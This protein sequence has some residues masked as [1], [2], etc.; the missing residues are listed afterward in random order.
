MSTQTREPFSF[1]TRP[2]TFREQ[3]ILH[4]MQKCGAGTRE[5][6]D[7]W[8]LFVN[9]MECRLDE[10][11]RIPELFGLDMDEIHMLDHELSLSIGQ[12]ERLSALAKGLPKTMNLDPDKL[13]PQKQ[14][15]EPAPTADE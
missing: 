7:Y 15:D 9:L 12:S 11:Q 5:K 13:Q 1:H 8:H 3:L 2:I 14:A 4:E 10:P 6:T